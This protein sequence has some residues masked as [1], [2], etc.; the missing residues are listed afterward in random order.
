MVVF[1]VITVDFSV[2][3]ALLFTQM[4]RAVGL[5]Q[6]GIAHVLLIFEDG[7]DRAGIPPA[8]GNGFYAFSI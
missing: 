6:L 8:S 3:N 4:V 7:Q 2:V 1:N 5:L